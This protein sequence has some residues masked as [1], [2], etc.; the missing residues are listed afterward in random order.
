MINI[1]NFITEKLRINKDT[2]PIISKAYEEIFEII[3]NYLE[4]E[5]DI[6]YEDYDVTFDELQNF[7]NISFTFHNVNRKGSKSYIHNRYD[8]SQLF[9]FIRWKLEDEGYKYKL[10]GSYCEHAS[11]RYVFKIK[12]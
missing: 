3:S 8:F 2:Q 9:D 5:F 6:T 12:K 11:K 4:K 1:N 7:F 10:F